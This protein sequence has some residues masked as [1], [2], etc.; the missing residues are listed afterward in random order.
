MAF[1]GASH[2]G[3]HHPIANSGSLVHSFE[4]RQAEHTMASRAIDLDTRPGVAFDAVGVFWS[5]LAIVWTGVLAAGMVFLWRKRDMP[6]LRIRS[7][8]L[9]MGAVLMLHTYWLCVT[10]G[11]VYGALMP[12]A[13]E[14]WIMSIWLPFGIGLFQASNSQFLYISNAQ[15]KFVRPDSVGSSRSGLTEKLS[16]A[17]E[18]SL[19][20]RFRKLDY[21]RRM[22]GYVCAGMVVQVR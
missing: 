4:T 9:S 2:A 3:P 15:K 13:I 10:L 1:T 19:I 7:L 18:T 12:T 21:P 11:Y 20:A 8:P 22:L 16:S 14:F 5:V 17:K 6:H